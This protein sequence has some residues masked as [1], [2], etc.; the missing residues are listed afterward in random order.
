MCDKIYQWLLCVNIGAYQW[1]AHTD[2]F[3]TFILLLFYLCI[4]FHLLSD[5]E[6]FDLD[7]A[8]YKLWV[9]GTGRRCRPIDSFHINNMLDR[10]ASDRLSFNT[11]VETIASN[12]GWYDLHLRVCASLVWWLWQ[13]YYPDCW[14]PLLICA[15]QF[16]HSHRRVTPLINYHSRVTAS[17]DWLTTLL[18]VYVQSLPSFSPRQITRRYYNVRTS[19]FRVGLF[20]VNLFYHQNGLEVHVM[21][22]ESEMYNAQVHDEHTELIWKF[23]QCKSFAACRRSPWA[24]IRLVPTS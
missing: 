5:T 13:P 8:W 19:T 24:P 10:K 18:A 11:G 1:L 20:E 14:L 4:K 16:L 17:C 2:G 21:Y 23:K 9:P 12:P 3:N 22:H 7:D 6:A 15:Q